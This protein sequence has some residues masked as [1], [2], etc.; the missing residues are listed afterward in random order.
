LVQKLL[1]GR[2]TDKKVATLIFT[3]SFKTTQLQCTAI[4][5]LV[6]VSLLVV[7]TL[8]A[9]PHLVILQPDTLVPTHPFLAVILELPVSIYVVV[10]MKIIKIALFAVSQLLERFQSRNPKILNSNSY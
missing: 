4:L 2:K 9:I 6:A 10:N 5:P 8:V 3:T 7:A 1:I